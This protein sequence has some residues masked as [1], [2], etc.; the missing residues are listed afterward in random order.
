MEEEESRAEPQDTQYDIHDED[1]VVEPLRPKPNKQKTSRVENPE[2]GDIQIEPPSPEK[3]RP[4]D[5]SF[6]RP[7]KSCTEYVGTLTNCDSQLD[8]EMVHYEIRTPFSMMTLQRPRRYQ[9]LQA[10]FAM[11][12]LLTNLKANHKRYLLLRELK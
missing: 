1:M 7:G 6:E 4:S 2:E 3:P 10:F 8:H 5:E 9:L 12:A 11:I